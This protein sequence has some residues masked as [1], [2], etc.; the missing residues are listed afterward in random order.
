MYTFHVNIYIVFSILCVCV[1][2]YLEWVSVHSGFGLINK[3]TIGHRQQQQIQQVSLR[4]SLSTLNSK[5]HKS[6]HQGK[7]LKSIKT[8]LFLSKIYKK[9]VHIHNIYKIHIYTI[10]RQ[11]IFIWKLIQYFKQ[12]IFSLVRFEAGIRNWREKKTATCL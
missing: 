9:Y 12:Q 3:S 6:S 5:H 11:S 7:N 4:Q 1:C 10:Y 2:A 8:F